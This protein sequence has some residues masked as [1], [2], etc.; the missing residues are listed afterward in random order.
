MDP[1]QTK[2]HAAEEMEKPNEIPASHDQSW[3]QSAGSSQSLG[4]DGQMAIGG[5]ATSPLYNEP[6]LVQRA[7]ITLPE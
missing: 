4:Q 7:G 3:G 6:K 5:E 2:V 1:K